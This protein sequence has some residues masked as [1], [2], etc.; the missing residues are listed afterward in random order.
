MTAVHGTKT[1]FTIDGVAYTGF[2]RDSDADTEA[3]MH[4]ITAK[5]ASV[6]SKSY[7]SGLIDR[8]YAIGGHYDNGASD[9]PRTGI[10]PL[11]GGAAVTML[12]HPEGTD[13][14][15]PQESVSILVKNYKESSPVDDVIRWT[16]DIQG[17]GE[18]TEST[19]A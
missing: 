12:Y 16:A 18:A 9:T 14:G 10:K 13:T 8:T 4:D 2:I 3:D 5:G 19:Q 17:T 7:L 11:V 1:A 6:E 15:L